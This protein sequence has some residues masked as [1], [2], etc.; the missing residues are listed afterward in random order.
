MGLFDKSSSRSSSTVDQSTKNYQAGVDAGGALA[1][2]GGVAAGAGA[3]AAQGSITVNQTD[4][5][6]F[7][8][9][10][11]V[12][13]SA[14]EASTRSTDSAIVA[15][16][17]ASLAAAGIAGDASRSVAELA[18]GQP[19]GIP[20]AKLVWPLAIAGALIAFAVFRRRA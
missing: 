3:I 12:V 11:D 19:V 2:G 9:A 8:F 5:G 20:W 6:S 18:A 14:L 17:S 10:S 7:R 1:Q 13:R 15:A 4:P 16:Q